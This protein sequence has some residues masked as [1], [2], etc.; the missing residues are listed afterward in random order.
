M[1][2]W[3]HTVMLM[4]SLKHLPGAWRSFAAF[5]HPTAAQH[6]CQRSSGTHLF[7]RRP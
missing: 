4:T 2:G 6:M 5:L 7:G 3:Q 1:Q